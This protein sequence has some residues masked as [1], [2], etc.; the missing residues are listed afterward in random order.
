VTEIKK[1]IV[2]APADVTVG[3]LPPE[4]S[5]VIQ[6]LID[7]KHLNLAPAVGVALRMT[8]AE[9]RIIGAHLQRKADEA[10]ALSSRL[11]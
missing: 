1:W 4:R 10:E 9:A 7:P 6:L 5:V 2:I 3:V 11:Q 8:P